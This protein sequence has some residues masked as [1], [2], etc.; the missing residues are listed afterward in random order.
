MNM[1]LFNLP[2]HLKHTILEYQSTTNIKKKKK[3][4]THDIKGSIRI[5]T[6]PENCD[7]GFQVLPGGD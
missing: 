4:T 6:G 5:M 1:V 7:P 3:N 2:S